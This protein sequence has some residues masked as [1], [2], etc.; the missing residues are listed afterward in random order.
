[1]V[2]IGAKGLAKEV[3]EVFAQ[4]NEIDNLFFFDNVSSDLPPLLFERF[5]ILRSFEELQRTF[6][7][8]GDSRFVLG[9]GNPILRARLSKMAMAQGGILTSAISSRAEIGSFGNVIGEGSTILSGAIITNGVTI[10]RGCLINPHCSISHDAKIGDFVEMSPGVRITGHAAIG[11]FSNLGTNAVVLPKISLGENVIVGAGAVV[12]K[13]VP[14][15]TLV[16]GVPA[17]MKKKVDPL[18]VE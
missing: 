6:E 8:S 16:V 5:Q 4:R 18:P 11:R 3:L 15:N 7:V 14:A 12:N 10:G 17:V 2:I 13:D 1:M 9:L